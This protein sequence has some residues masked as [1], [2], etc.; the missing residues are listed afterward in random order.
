[1]ELLEA[2]DDGGRRTHG[3]RTSAPWGF[4]MCWWAPSSLDSFPT[5]MSS[6]PSRIVHCVQRNTFTHRDV[7][8]QLLTSIS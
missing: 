6:D 7:A 1:M 2:D 3:L 8:P 4:R 5:T